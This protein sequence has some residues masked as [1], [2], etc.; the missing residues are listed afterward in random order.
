MGVQPLKNKEDPGSAADGQSRPRR[1]RS[2][3][4]MLSRGL[5]R[6]LFKPAERWLKV[7]VTPVDYC[8]PIPDT[9]ALTAADFSRSIASEGIEWRAE[10]QLRLTQDLVARFGGEFTPTPNEGLSLADSFILYATLRNR[11]PRRIVEI[12]SGAS[13]VII[14]K[15]LEMNRREGSA[16]EFVSVDPFPPR[17]LLPSA[18]AGVTLIQA[19][20]QSL[21]VADLCDTDVLFIDSS[22]VSRF[23]SDVNYE[24]LELVPRVPTGCW[25]HWHDIMLPTDYPREWLRHGNMF[26]NEAYLVQAFLAFNDAFEIRYAARYLETAEVD[27]FT[28]AMPHFVPGD[29]QQRSSSLWAE[30]VR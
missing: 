22:H 15:A 12:G 18:G 24:V 9:S 17:W 28:G 27:R 11:R 21:P 4:G 10:E 7:H 16:A 6:V 2:V 3:P 8:S 29:P 23:G 13:T 30:R 19:P 5:A 26:W 20:V 14:M 25:V 1:V